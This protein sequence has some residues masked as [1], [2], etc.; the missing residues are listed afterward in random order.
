VTVSSFYIGR[1]EVT[2]R[3]W[4]SVMG[5]NPS[6]YTGDESRPVERVSWND[7]QQFITALNAR[8]GRTYRLPTEAEWEYAAR[9]EKRFALRLGM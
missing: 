5:S 8:T 3:L 4:T 7:I 1:Y 6:Y 9:G 2:Q